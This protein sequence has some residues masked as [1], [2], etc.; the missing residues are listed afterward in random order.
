[1]GWYPCVNFKKIWNKLLKF[2]EP[3][4]NQR[5]TDTA[6]TLHTESEEIDTTA[7]NDHAAYQQM[8]H[9]LVNDISDQE[10]SEW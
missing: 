5:A 4:K 9:S 10:F 2:G 8:L 7:E 3:E 6:A 1:M